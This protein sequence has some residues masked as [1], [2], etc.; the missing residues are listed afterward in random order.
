[1]QVYGGWN[2]R[3]ANPD[4]QPERAANREL[5]VMHSLDKSLHELSVFSARY[6]NAIREDAINA[7]S[8]HVHG[9]EY[10]G[11][12]IDIGRLICII[13]GRRQW[14]LSLMILQPQNG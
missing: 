12:L 9:A 5:V 2:G 13:R 3:N 7:S 1:M 8:R 4:L 14:I 11:R 6:D 10:R